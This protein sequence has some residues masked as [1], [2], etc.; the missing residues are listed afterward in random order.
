MTMWTD[1][2]NHLLDDVLR[3]LLFV[4][5]AILIGVGPSQFVALVALSQLSESFQH[6]NLCL[7]QCLCL[8][9][10]FGRPGDRLWATAAPA[11]RAVSLLP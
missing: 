5:I 8:C 4:V 1:N 11:P 2:R 6:D 3:G 9:L 7:C 10:W